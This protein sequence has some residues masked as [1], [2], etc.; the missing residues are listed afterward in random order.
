MKLY[1]HFAPTIFW[2][3]STHQD[4]WWQEKGQCQAN[5]TSKSGQ[6]ASHFHCAFAMHYYLTPIFFIP[7]FREISWKKLYLSIPFCLG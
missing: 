1:S 4:Y 2:D 3:M 7:Y 6:G 5:P